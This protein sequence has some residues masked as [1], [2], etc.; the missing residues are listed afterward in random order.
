MLFLPSPHSGVVTDFLFALSG[1]L[2]H[3][4]DVL[5]TLLHFASLSLIA[6]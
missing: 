5:S 4:T 6:H 1:S 2:I 3:H